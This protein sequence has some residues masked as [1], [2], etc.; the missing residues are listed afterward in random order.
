MSWLRRGCSLSSGLLLAFAAAHA[1]AQEPSELVPL[2]E[3][4]HAATK[5]ARLAKTTAA[6]SFRRARAPCS[7]GRFGWFMF[8]DCGEVIAMRI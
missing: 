8:S 2:L 6:M 3:L 4:P 1:Q 7:A 5:T